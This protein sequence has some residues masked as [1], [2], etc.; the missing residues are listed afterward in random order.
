MP[1]IQRPV[2]ADG[3]PDKRLT[4]RLGDA[5]PSTRSHHSAALVARFRDSAAKFLV[6][7]LGSYFDPKNGTT[8]TKIERWFQNWGQNMT[9][10][11]EPKNFLFSHRPGAIFA[12][13]G[14]PSFGASCLPFVSSPCPCRPL[15]WPCGRSLCGQRSAITRFGTQK[16][17]S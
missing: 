7:F 11:M 17:E 9:P 13:G 14:R 6:P 12:R 5:F 1:S 4:R 8:S 2:A 16:S 15:W 3:Q 10:K